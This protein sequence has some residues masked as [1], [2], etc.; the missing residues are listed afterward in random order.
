MIDG[1]GKIN[2][3]LSSWRVYSINDDYLSKRPED[4]Q[5]RLG[6][7]SGQP[8]DGDTLTIRFG[9]LPPGYHDTKKQVGASLSALLNC[10]PKV[11]L[12]K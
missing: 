4:E 3:Y 11:G 9:G 7:I 2:A 8:K 1:D 10:S 5:D 6:V 12:G